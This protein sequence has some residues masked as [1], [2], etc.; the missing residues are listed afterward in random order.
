[1]NPALVAATSTTKGKT[2]DKPS[3]P[4][5]PPAAQAAKKKKKKSSKPDTDVKEVATKLAGFT[6]QE[7]TF[8][9]PVTKTKTPKE[10]PVETTITSVPKDSVPPTDPAKRL[11]NL[12]KKIKDIETLEAKIKSGELKNPDKDQLEKIKRKK[13]VIKE[14]QDLEKSIKWFI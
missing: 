3:I 11:K 2:G 6:I 13:D 12:K 8:G 5:L 9:P 10:T 7:P 4:G 1:M 14:I